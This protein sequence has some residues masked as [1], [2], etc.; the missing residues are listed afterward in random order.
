MKPYAGG[1]TGSC[2]TQKVPMIKTEKMRYRN[3]SMIV[4]EMNIANHSF[5]SV[6]YD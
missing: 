6:L 2:I 1:A 5:Y 3:N 4:T